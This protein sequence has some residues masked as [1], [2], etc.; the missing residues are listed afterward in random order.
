M[1]DKKLT[2]FQR[3]GVWLLRIYQMMGLAKHQLLITAFG[4]SS[5]CPQTPTCSR[6]WAEQIKMHGT[7]VGSWRGFQRWITCR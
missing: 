5:Q 3:L 7:I 1:Q 2:V 4:Y 6:Y